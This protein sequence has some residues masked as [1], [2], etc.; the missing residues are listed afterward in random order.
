MALAPG[1]PGEVLESDLNNRAQF[2]T[3]NPD[4]TPEGAK[5]LTEEGLWVTAEGMSA[6]LK[7][8]TPDTEE[9][10]FQ[11]ELW[12]L[13]PRIGIQRSPVTHTVLEGPALCHVPCAP[14]TK[15]LV[16]SGHQESS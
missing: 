16:S 8:E 5:S 9:L 7:G 14:Q 2:P 3:F 1:E 13:E 15:Y 6:I 10:V 12:R 11:G 4:Q